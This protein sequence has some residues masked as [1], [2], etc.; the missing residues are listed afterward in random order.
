[1]TGTSARQPVLF[2]GHG[3]PLNVLADNVWTQSWQRIGREITR[4]R[5][6]VVVSAHWCTHGIGVTAMPMPPT[7][8]DFGGFPQAMFDMRYPAPGDPALAQRIR[9]LLAPLPVVLDGSWGLDH[10]T[11]SVLCK[12]FPAADIPVVQLSIDMTKPPSFH[13]ET[14]ALLAP[15]R[16]E[17]V[18]IV[19]T[20]N[21]VH[22]LM[23]YQRHADIAYEWAIR[24]NDFI[25]GNLIAGRLGALAD[26]E[27]FG[28]A[29]RLS[30]PTPDHYYPLLYAAGAAGGDAAEIEIDGIVGGSMSMLSAAWGK[31]R[32]ATAAPH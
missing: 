4:P 7:I 14:G 6:I 9:E 26:Y 1:M 20:G 27:A 25:R 31:N 23:L 28:E 10:G 5:A 17:G 18:L 19:G 13:L 3:T 29:A 22:N 2:L 12:V 16:D 30:V 21:V 8:H 11:W 32:A 15:L 24:F